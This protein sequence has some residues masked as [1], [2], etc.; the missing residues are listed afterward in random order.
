MPW[1]LLLARRGACPTTRVQARNK[2]PKSLL[3][4]LNAQC[5]ALI[6]TS[7]NYEYVAVMEAETWTRGVHASHA[8]QRTADGVNHSCS[9]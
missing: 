8:Q 1:P 5:D 6:Y 2:V 4:A 3:S 7:V 9:P